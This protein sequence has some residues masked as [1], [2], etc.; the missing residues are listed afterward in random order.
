MKRKRQNFAFLIIA[1]AIIVYSIVNLAVVHVRLNEA[2]AEKASM[3]QSIELQKQT[4][5]QLKEDISNAGEAGQIQKIA[6]QK[7][8]LVQNGEI[9]FYDMGH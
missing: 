8:G 1:L 6:R 9:I 7:L 4:N 2:E 3:Q 5:S